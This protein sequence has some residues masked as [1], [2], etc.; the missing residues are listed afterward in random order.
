MR[1]DRIQG[2]AQGRGGEARR[3]RVGVV[4]QVVARQGLLEFDGT[5]AS[6]KAFP[7]AS[8]PH[9]GPRTPSPAPRDASARLATHL[10]A[11]KHTAYVSPVIAVVE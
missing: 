6:S 5:A 2:P 7:R 9:Y 4:C 8:W 1:G 11:R 10:H 3:W